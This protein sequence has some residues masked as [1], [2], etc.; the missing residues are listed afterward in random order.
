MLDRKIFYLK[1]CS[2]LELAIDKA[3]TLSESLEKIWVDGDLKQRQKLQHLVFP[4]GLGYDKSNDQV[5][6]T[7][8]NAIFGS[9]PILSKEISN[10]KKGEPI[11]VNQFS[12]CV[13]HTYSSS[14][15][16]R[17]IRDMYSKKIFPEIK[18]YSW[19]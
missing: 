5:R 7:K 9:I 3:L 13:T 12:D 15:F 2:N 10:I 17:G 19:E 16:L 18:N 4:S 14:D 11:P 1:F 6:T 8:V